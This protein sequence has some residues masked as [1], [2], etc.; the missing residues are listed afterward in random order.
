MGP[1]EMKVPNVR[2]KALHQRPWVKPVFFIIRIGP[3][4]LKI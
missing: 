2:K 1:E 3:I 4:E